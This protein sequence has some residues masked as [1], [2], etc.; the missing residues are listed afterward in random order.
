VYFVKTL[1]GIQAYVLHRMMKQTCAVVIEHPNGEDET[2]KNV[3][4]IKTME[5]GTLSIRTSDEPDVF[6]RGWDCKIREII[7]PRAGM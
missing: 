2:I 7:T 6:K 3:I 4:S 1:K 5:D